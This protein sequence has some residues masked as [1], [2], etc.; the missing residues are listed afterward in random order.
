M[1]II[2]RLPPKDKVHF[3]SFKT[4]GAGIKTSRN[5]YFWQKKIQL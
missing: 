5:Y 4:E 3:T 2:S 1:G